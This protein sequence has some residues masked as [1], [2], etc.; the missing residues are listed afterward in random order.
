MRCKCFQIT[1]LI[2]TGV[3]ILSLATLLM[4]LDAAAATKKVKSLRE[5]QD[6]ANHAKPGDVVLL[7][8][9]AYSGNVSLRGKGMPGKPIVIGAEKPGKTIHTSGQFRITGSH[10]TIRDFEFRGNKGQPVFLDHAKYVRVVNNFFNRCGSK[11]YRGVVQISGDSD[12]CRVDHNTFDGTKISMSI[13]A[14][15]RDGK[16]PER[17][18]VDHNL[19][20]NIPRSNKNS[21]EVIQ[22]NDNWGGQDHSFRALIEFNLVENYQGDESEVISIK[23]SNC[24]VRYNTIRHADGALSLRHGNGHK[25]YGNFIFNSKGMEITGK[26]AE[27]NNNYVENAD[28]IGIGFGGGKKDYRTPDNL[29]LANNTL[30]KLSQDIFIGFNKNWHTGHNTKPKG[31]KFLNNLIWQDRN[32]VF[33]QAADINAKYEANIVHTTGSGQLGVSKSGV[34]KA[35]PSFKKSGGIQRPTMKSVVVDKGVSVSQVRIDIDGQNRSSKQDI[36]ADEI[37]SSAITIKPLDKSDVGHDFNN[38]TDPTIDPPKPPSNLRV[39]S[40]HP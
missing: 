29:L 35:N 12:D 1:L 23:G 2:R 7:A 26:N 36:G 17:L 40:T 13:Q 24:T 39:L 34:K 25:V 20:M 15:D 27:V 32:K 6:T 19:F 28:R 10:M 37:L 4:S 38:T 3:G 30:V 16:V 5:L 9:G 18:R 11:T 14:I 33:N 22:I 21:G 8:P 31:V